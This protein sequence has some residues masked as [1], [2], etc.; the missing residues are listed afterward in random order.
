MTAMNTGGSSVLVVEDD[1]STRESLVELLGSMGF[2][3]VAAENGLEALEK[4]RQHRPCVVLLDLAMPLLDGRGFVEAT[5]SD[6]ELLPPVP[7]VVSA[8]CRTPSKRR[9]ALGLRTA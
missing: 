3:V 4:I 8:G 6:P 5:R 7:I 2:Q 1:L 9:N